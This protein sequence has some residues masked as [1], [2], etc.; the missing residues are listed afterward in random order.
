LY[1]ISEILLK[2]IE[3]L[4]SVGNISRSGRTDPKMRFSLKDIDDKIYMRA[5]NGHSIAK[6]D[7][8]DLMES[9]S[10]DQIPAAIHG[11]TLEAW[12]SI[13][14]KGLSPMT[15]RT[16]QMACGLPSD[17]LV[18]SGIRPSSTIYIWIDVRSAMEAGIPFFRTENGVIC[19]PKVIPSQ[20]FSRVENM[21]TGD[22]L[23]QK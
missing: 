12:D 11:T 8:M 10:Q 9:I 23:H 4:I 3:L 16:I 15:R 13:R 17:P 20:F 18:K 1:L 21:N 22:V 7:E 19:T 14:D 6:V 5:N 2:I